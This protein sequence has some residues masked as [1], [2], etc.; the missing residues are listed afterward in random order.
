MKERSSCLVE[1]F[2]ISPF[3]V[4]CSISSFLP[5][6]KSPW[7]GSPYPSTVSTPLPE[8]ERWNKILLLPP[9]LDCCTSHLVF[10]RCEHCY[11][12]FCLVCNLSFGETMGLRSNRIFCSVHNPSCCTSHLVLP[13][14]FS[15]SLTNFKANISATAALQTP[16][17]NCCTSYD[18][19]NRAAVYI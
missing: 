6:R 10:C 11:I 18:F 8:T 17:L 3:P 7:V 19:R 16:S 12:S 5:S 2:Y 4:V 13:Q 14:I 1:Y 15:F 9:E